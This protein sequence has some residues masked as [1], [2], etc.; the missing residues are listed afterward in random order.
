MTVY[1][2]PQPPS[3]EITPEHVW[4]DR[5]RLLTSAALLA[6]GA[7]TPFSA[8]TAALAALPATPNRDFTVMEKPTPEKDVVSYNNFYEFGLEKSDPARYAGAMKVRPWTVQVEGEVAKPGIYGIEDL[9]GLDAMQDRVYR[10]RC[11]EGWSMVIPWVG[12]PL[13]SLLKKVEPTSN[14][15][16][17]EF[18]TAEQPAAMPGLRSSVIDWPY[19]EGLRMDEAMH[20]LTLL[21][22]GLY[23]KVLPNQNGAPVRMVIPWKY[24]FKSGKSIVKIRVTEKEPL[25][26]WVQSAPH[27][28][29]FYAN[30][31]PNVTHPRWSQ[32]TERVIGEGNALFERRRPTLMFNGYADQ[33]ASLYAGMDLRKHY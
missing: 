18:Y 29:G 32:A 2:F 12:Y 30:V 7:A 16:Y 21:T 10:M 17:V 19:R 24:G 4:Q 28:Y 13:A 20:P 26:S 15:K 1:R 31:N 6:T 25:T 3:S 9:L 11:V 27:E 14:G 23:G 22:F 5:R 33:V 8:A